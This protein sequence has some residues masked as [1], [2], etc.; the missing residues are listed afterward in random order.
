MPEAEDGG[1]RFVTINNN[2]ELGFEETIDW[3]DDNVEGED[4][5]VIFL[6]PPLEVMLRADLNRSGVSKGGRDDGFVIRN[7]KQLSGG[8][9]LIL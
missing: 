4:D 2:L 6:G 3:G 9:A 1:V 7:V 5:E 8:E